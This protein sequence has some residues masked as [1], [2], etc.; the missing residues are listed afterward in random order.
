MVRQFVCICALLLSVTSLGYSQ[1]AGASA[2][3]SGIGRFAFTRGDFVYLQDAAGRA[4]QQLAKGMDPSLSPSGRALAFTVNAKGPQDPDRTI[5]IMDLQTKK[6]TDFKSLAPHISYLP[7]W[8]PD[9]TRIAFN[10]FLDSRWNV[11]VMDVAKGEWTSLTKDLPGKTDAFLSSWTPEG[12]TILCQDL[13]T[14]YEVGAE[15]RIA[16]QWKVEKIAGENGITSSTRFLFSPDRRYLLFDAAE[17]PDVG[18]ILLYDLQRGTLRRLTTKT[19]E[20]SQPVW[21]GGA[22]EFLFANYRKLSRSRGV[23]DVYRSSLT[24]GKPMLVIQNASN[25]SVTAK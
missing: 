16:N 21:L 10:L 25:V 18:Y 5:R 6:T 17:A 20:A 15:G 2:T 8:S 4:P 9:E 7:M 19:L 1:T 13:G 12:K 24:A 11:A 22:N 3:A 14:I 23:F